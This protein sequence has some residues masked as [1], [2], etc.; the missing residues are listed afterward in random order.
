MAPLNSTSQEKYCFRK[1][2]TVIKWTISK[3]YSC[4][5]KEKYWS[6]GEEYFKL[7]GRC[8]LLNGWK[9]SRD[10]KERVMLERGKSTQCGIARFIVRPAVNY[11]NPGS[12]GN[13]KA[14]QDRTHVKPIWL[15]QRSLFIREEMA[16]YIHFYTVYSLQRHIHWQA[17]IVCL[18]LK[19]T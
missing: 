18:F 6:R 7:T 5:I 16:A 1:K 15:M 3:S 2:K 4:T 11:V 12:S 14:G 9:A 13:R 10:P 19:V 8:K 17:N